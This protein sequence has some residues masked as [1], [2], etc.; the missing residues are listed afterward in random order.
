[1][2]KMPLRRASDVISS[3]SHGKPQRCVGTTATV[4]G[5]I[6]RSNASAVML[7]VTGSTS[8]NTGVSPA[9]RAISGTTQNVSAGITISEPGANEGLQNVVERHAAEGCRD[10]RQPAD[11]GAEGLGEGRDVRALDQS[12]RPR[13]NADDLLRV[14]DDA[15]AVA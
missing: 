8:T 9:A 3:M 5:P 10:R 12:A 2:T 14:G 4:R 7:N 13:E 1:M 11:S 6:A 15:C